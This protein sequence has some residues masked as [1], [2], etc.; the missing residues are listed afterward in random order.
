MLSGVSFKGQSLGWYFLFYVNVLEFLDIYADLIQF[1][2]DTTLLCHYRNSS[3]LPDISR[4]LLKVNKWC[5]TNF[6]TP[7]TIR[8]KLLIL[9]TILPIEV[10]I[11]RGLFK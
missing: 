11:S 3:K 7:N 2:D 10:Q 1:S 9:K 4:E 5:K 6:L 8:K